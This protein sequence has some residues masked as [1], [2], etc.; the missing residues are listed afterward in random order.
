MYNNSL[1]LEKELNTLITLAK[2]NKL[3][4]SLSLLGTAGVLAN[5]IIS[6]LNNEQY[7]TVKDLIESSN[8]SVEKKLKIVK[9]IEKKYDSESKGWLSSII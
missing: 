4:D 2:H 7:E 8:M 6:L 9:D 1:E 3:K 5:L